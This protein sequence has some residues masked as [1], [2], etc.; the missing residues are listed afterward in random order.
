MNEFIHV[1]TKE[2]VKI[3]DNSDSNFL[4]LNSGMK[5]DRALFAQKYVPLNMSNT[6]NSINPESFM[7]TPTNITVNPKKQE[8]TPI[9]NEN[10]IN[11]SNTPIDPI[12]FLNSPSLGKI[13][14][15]DNIQKI[16]TSKYIDIPESQ[17]VQIKDLNSESS[18]TQTT[19]QSLE[20]QKRILMENHM[21]T[22]QQGPGY[23]DENDPN[24]INSLLDSY[25]KPEPIILLN[26]NGLTEAQETM[27]QQQIELIGEDPYAEKIK[28]YRTS[29]GLSSQPV[30]NPSPSQPILEK[31]DD[32]AGP[33]TQYKQPTQTME[34]PT[35][36]LFKKFKRNHNLTVI[37][38]IKD[39]I[40]K[41]DFIKVMAD[42]LEGDIIQYY[43]DEIFTKFLG[44]M[45]NIKTDIYNQIHK[46]VYGCLPSDMNDDEDETQKKDEN[47]VILFPGK[48]TKTGELTFK[49]LNKGGKVVDVT[50]KVGESKGYKPATKNDII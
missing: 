42:G 18:I 10:Y 20:D 47:V 32:V 27:R 43:T 15:L 19:N 14:G 7:S 46:E 23:V 35:T 8:Q 39:K 26:E 34:D 41:P 28:K 13:D 4:I 50:T 30:R 24:A 48:P 17:R 37:L 2:I 6:N 11:T 29:K 16:D 21:R 45:Q 36:A 44:D 12:D 22:S 9:V 3:I 38:K 33:N 1:D 25:K 49:Y 31:H 40:S 5:I